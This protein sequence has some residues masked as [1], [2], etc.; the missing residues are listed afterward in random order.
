MPSTNQL[1]HDVNLYF[2]LKR[3]IP[4]GWK[5]LERDTKIKR[6]DGVFKNFQWHKITCAVRGKVRYGIYIRKKG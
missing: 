2:A 6:G 4:D 5:L 3:G 1:A